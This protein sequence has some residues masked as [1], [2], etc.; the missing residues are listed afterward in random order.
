VDRVIAEAALRQH[1][2]V[3]RGQLLSS[4]IDRL[5]S[6]GGCPV[7]TFPRAI[8]DLAAVAG[9]RE[10]ERAFNQAEVL[11]LTDRLSI[12]DLLVRYPGRSGT[13]VLQTILGGEA[14]SH[15][16][17]RNDFEE[18]FARF[19]EAHRLPRPRFNADLVICGRHFVADCLWAEK[20]LIVEL[21]GR[22]THGTR[23]AFEADR[24]RDRVLATEGWRVIRV[25]WRQL[26]GD[27][28]ALVADLGAILRM[29]VGSTLGRD[30]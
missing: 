8:L 1:G 21:D 30:E 4:V 5:L 6:S 26:L 19:V 28:T 16:I 13:A 29:P 14:A 2:V 9:K 18:R 7:T 25:T 3:E 12:P 17:A 27:E 23:R 22:A 10:V 11:Q 24:E 15:G 20:R